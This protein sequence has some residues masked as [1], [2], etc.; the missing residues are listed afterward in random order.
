M[1]LRTCKEI[2]F[3]LVT[4][5]AQNVDSTAV[6]LNPGDNIQRAVDAH[7][8][9]STFYLN[10]GVYRLQSISPA[11][12]DKFIGATD[13]AGRPAA[14][15][16]GSKLITNFVSSG[17]A[18]VAA[19]QMPG[20][21]AVDPQP[22]NCDSDHPRCAYLN[23]LF[24]DGVRLKHVASRPALTS[25][26]WYFDLGSHEIY[27]YD[28][29]TGHVIELAVATYAFPHV[30]NLNGVTVKHLIIEKYA[31]PSGNGALD[32]KF[33]D[34][35]VI[36][37]NEIRNNHGGGAN[38]GNSVL[39]QG[40]Y[41]HHNGQIGILSTGR[42]VVVDGNEI[43]FNNADGYNYSWQGGGAKFMNGSIYCKV[44]NNWVHD[45]Y[46][47][48]LWFDWGN[49]HNT[50]EGNR[51]AR[52]YGMGLFYEMSFDGTIRYNISD[53]DGPDIKG[54]SIWNGA[55]ILSTNSN[56]VTAYANT[57]LSSTNGLAAARDSRRGTC[58]Y[59]FLPS[60]GEA[61][62]VKDLNYH[63]NV[64]VQEAGNGSAAG[65]VSE[66]ISLFSSGSDHFAQNTYKLDN[67]TGRFF[68]W[69]GSKGFTQWQS[70]GQDTA[71]VLKSSADARFPSTRFVAGARVQTVANTP[72]YTLPS[73]TDGVLVTTLTSGA[74]GTVTAIAG[75]IYAGQSV[76]WRVRYDAG[77]IGWSVEANL[78]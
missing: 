25:G 34:N 72:V 46:G 59:D 43:S 26:T 32:A 57:I 41:V 50:M 2:V 19:T 38:I 51:T 3:F 75:P 63:D 42:Q 22:G 56:R 53:H 78:Q 39:F 7:P 44:R 20:G 4:A 9:G 52:N 61:F 10:A 69:Q 55:G 17:S 27:V 62:S 65:F 73:R 18:W 11:V 6:V 23:D 31:N 28:N 8:S 67:S 60:Y 33:Q 47:P 29:P 13:A 14:I 16:N 24:S 1:P 76:W 36:V 45:N 58:P 74:A 70:A 37:N 48:G 49:Q 71:G 64:V 30:Y 12:G 40:N 15:L 77:A 5:A 21:L 68:E 35:W 54:K 66:D